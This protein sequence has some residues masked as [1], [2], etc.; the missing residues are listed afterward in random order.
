M[1]RHK[2]F[3]FRFRKE[4]TSPSRAALDEKISYDDCIDM[5]LVFEN[6]KWVFAI[7]SA[8][9]RKTKKCDVEKGEDQKD[10]R[11]WH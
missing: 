8:E 7:D 10:G 5:M 4:V 11:I 1:N 9:E 2:P 3:L 6:G